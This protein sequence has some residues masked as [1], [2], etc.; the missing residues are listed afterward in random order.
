MLKKMVAV[1]VVLVFAVSFGA[2]K[3]KEEKPVKK[4]NIF[5]ELQEKPKSE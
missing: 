1:A 5:K 2:C 3:K 4:K